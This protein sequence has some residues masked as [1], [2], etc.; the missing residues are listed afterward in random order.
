MSGAAPTPDEGKAQGGE[1]GEEFAFSSAV[2]NTLR[3][4]FPSDDPLDAATF[5]PIAFVNA[6]FPNERSLARMDT[7]LA[8][9]EK[10]IAKL[11]DE[12]FGAVV[13]QAAAGKQA[14]DEVDEV[15]TAIRD[16]F[17]KIK[18]IK[19]KAEESEVM[20]KEISWTSRN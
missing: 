16:L 1:A 13:S 7:Y 18:D 10:T 9:T 17:Q 8:Q 4:V 15:K 6:N 19:E 3:T 14:D 5:D 12:I 20:V 2:E 11:D